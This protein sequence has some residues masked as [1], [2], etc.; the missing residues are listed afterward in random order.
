M[1]YQD[2]INLG[3]KRTDWNDSVNVHNFGYG[4]FYLLKQV[5]KRVAVFVDWKE[6]DHPQLLLG[7]DAKCSRVTISEKEIRLLF[8]KE[9]QK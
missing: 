6:L 1:T 8:E 9:E 7:T 5:S 3:F 4:G 2:Y